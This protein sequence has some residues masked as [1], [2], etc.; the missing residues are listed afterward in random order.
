MIVIAV[1]A[2]V[3]VALY[4]NPI[5]AILAYGWSPLDVVRTVFS[6]FPIPRTWVTAE[7]C[8]VRYHYAEFA[9]IAFHYFSASSIISLTLR[10]KRP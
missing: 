10:S 2:P 1:A 6:A 8:S 7:L 9:S 3:H 4:W 5:F